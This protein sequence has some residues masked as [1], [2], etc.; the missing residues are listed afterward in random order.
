MRQATSLQLTGLLARWHAGDAE[1]FDELAPLVYGELHR[2]ARGYMRGERSAYTLQTTALVHEAYLKLLRT[3]HIAWKSREH[4]YAVA[5]KFMRRVL[6]DFARRRAAQKRGGRWER[7]RVVGE[8]LSIDTP[9]LTALDD[10]S[11]A[12]AKEDPRKAQ[13]V[14]LKFFGGFSVEDTAAALSISPETVMR[15][16]KFAKAWLARELRMTA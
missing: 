8:E 6:V 13:V 3:E 1:A 11:A 10:A 15:D 2:L 12:L 4:F 16:W 9:E 7:V 5:A 14:E